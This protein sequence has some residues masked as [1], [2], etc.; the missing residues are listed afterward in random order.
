MKYVLEYSNGL[1]DIQKGKECLECLKKFNFKSAKLKRMYLGEG[2]ADKLAER[3]IGLIQD[4]LPDF[5]PKPRVIL[6]EQIQPGQ[7][8]RAEQIIKKVLSG[9]K[10][11]VVGELKH[12]DPSTFKYL[13]HIPSDC[14]IRLFIDGSKKV[15][16]CKEEAEKF[17]KERAAPITIKYI[18]KVNGSAWI[19]DRWLAGD[20]FMIRFGTDLKEESLGKTSHTIIVTDK[21]H[22]T[23]TYRAFS[24]LWESNSKELKKRGAK[25]WLFYKSKRFIT[26]P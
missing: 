2:G 9:F 14:P 26:S 15:E 19:H 7:K 22:I 23:K 4:I 10:G 21:P 11:E 16:K 3:W 12:I 5:G 17:V 18:T 13:K 24:E 20:N 8:D 6:E 1:R 25:C